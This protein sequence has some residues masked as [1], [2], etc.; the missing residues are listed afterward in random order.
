MTT[1]EKTLEEI[2]EELRTWASA[3]GWR[4][5]GCFPVEKQDDGSAIISLEEGA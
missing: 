3:N 5:I 1:Q 4:Y 2:E